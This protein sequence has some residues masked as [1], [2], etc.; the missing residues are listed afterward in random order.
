M[1]NGYMFV[2]STICLTRIY[3][4]EKTFCYTLSTQW[5]FDKYLKKE[6]SEGRVKRQGG[7]KGD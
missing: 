6:G 2:R 4:R 7:G 5:G 1:F 3:M